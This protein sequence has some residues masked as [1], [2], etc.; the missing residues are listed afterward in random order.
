[1]R[2]GILECGRPPERVV[3]NHGA[4]PEI[5]AR[6]LEGHGFSFQTF[7][8]AE[9]E[10]PNAADTCE[11]WLIPGTSHGVYERHAYLPR[12]EELI[13]D[14]YDREIPIVGVCFGHQVVARALGG[15][16]EKFSGGWSVGRH[17]YTFKS[18]GDLA[19]N[20]WHQDQVLEA[21]DGAET[22]ATSVFCHH[23]GLKYG[24]RAW[25]VQAHPEYSAEILKD[26]IAARRGASSIPESQL[27]TAELQLSQSL[28][29][30]YIVEEIARFFHHAEKHAKPDCNGL[31]G[32]APKAS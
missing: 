13:R 29:E 12:L 7:N 30:A 22:I 14:A 23:A 10:F 2:I 18:A 24:H 5:F 6:L 1:M 8:V 27:D 16:V 9:L 26:M 28:D 15:R 3:R 17:V 19:L 20:A 21:P 11:G 4:Y 25:T 31:Y 32:S